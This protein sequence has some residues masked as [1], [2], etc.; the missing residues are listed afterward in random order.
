MASALAQSW[1]RAIAGRQSHSG[2]A[3][4]RYTNEA[5][6]R[7]TTT[8][9]SSKTKTWLAHKR[10]VTPRPY[11]NASSEMLA[12]QRDGEVLS[13]SRVRPGPCKVVLGTS[14]FCSCAY[15]H[16]LREGPLNEKH[17]LFAWTEA[18]LHHPTAAH[19]TGTLPSHGRFGKPSPDTH[20]TSCVP[21]Y[22]PESIR[23]ISHDLLH[24]P[25]LPV[26]LPHPVAEIAFAT[27]LA[28]R[29]ARPRGPSSPG[30]SSRLLGILG[31]TPLL[32]GASPRKPRG[33]GSRPLAPRP[34]IAMGLLVSTLS[35]RVL[36]ATTRT[37]SRSARRN[38]RM[39]RPPTKSLSIR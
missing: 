26:C 29:P 36:E 6:N 37:S 35:R 33:L 1:R 22:P 39:R 17:G 14:S 2:S 9:K 8:T 23:C 21:P 31:L 25:L 11:T 20:E 27:T 38:H 15:V 10:Q 5:G 13:R 30:G 4:K 7:R 24:G 28:R 19:V 18:C 34:V 16:V 32:T 12:G 3:S